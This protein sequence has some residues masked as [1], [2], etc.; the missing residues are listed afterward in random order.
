MATAPAN[1]Y[2]APDKPGQLRWWDGAAW[3]ENYAPDEAGAKAAAAAAK[4][5]AKV[6]ARAQKHEARELRH[7]QH[8][9]GHEEATY[10]S[11]LATWQTSRDEQARVL[12][13]VTT[14]TGESDADGV[15]LQPGEALYGHIATASLLEERAGQGEFV[16]R[17][18]GFSI[19]V[20]SIG[21]HSIRY[22]IGSSRGTYVA[23]P[24]VETAIDQGNLIV[25][26]QRVIFEGSLQTRE[27]QFSK[28][29]AFQTSPNGIAQFSVSNRQK[30]TVVQYGADLSAWFDLRLE[31]AMA[32][33]RN[34][35]P[36]LI[37]TTKADLDA[38][39]ARRP[40]APAVPGAASVAAATSVTATDAAT[41]TDGTTPTAAT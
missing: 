35:L 40:V 3:T 30:P 6:A 1:W 36:D 27:C 10:E 37:A 16:G 33:Y 11:A 18:Q 31:I 28:L 38:I 2:P 17:S 5:A 15:M 29:L 32:H 26:N 14:Y 9:Y 25:T 12:D 4:K 41:S 7:E 8:E 22:R 21:G 13:F 24:P 20:A 23:A 19:P 34:T 39:D